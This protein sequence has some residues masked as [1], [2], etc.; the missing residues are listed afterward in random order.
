[1]H[2]ARARQRCNGVK[3]KEEGTKHRRRRM[4]SP[5]ALQIDFPSASLRHKGVCDVA[6]LAHVRGAPLVGVGGLLVRA[7]SM[8]SV[9]FSVV[10]LRAGSRTREGVLALSTCCIGTAGRTVDGEGG[11]EDED[12]SCLE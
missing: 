3:G 7:G 11:A 5:H 2:V 1:M 8:F 10:S 4:N 6:Q 12:S 9:S